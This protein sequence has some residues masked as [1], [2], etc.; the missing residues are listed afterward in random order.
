VGLISQAGYA[1]VV[2]QAR[3]FLSGRS[4]DLLES[5]REKM[6][7]ASFDLQFERA[8]RYRDLLKAIETTLERQR[9]VNYFGADSDAR[10]PIFLG[11]TRKM[12][13]S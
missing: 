13:N 3:L 11:A 4:E 1:E 8:A 5:I 7:K 10:R 12:R 2:Q 6:E 9:V